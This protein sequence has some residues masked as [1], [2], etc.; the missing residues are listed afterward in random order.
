M[1]D[2]ISASKL[3]NNRFWQ[4]IPTCIDENVLFIQTLETHKVSR[5]R[6]DLA[7]EIFVG[8]RDGDCLIWVEITISRDPL[9]ESGLYQVSVKIPSKYAAT[10]QTF[11]TISEIIGE[12]C[13][14]LKY[15]Q[16]HYWLSSVFIGA[17]MHL[18]GRHIDTLAE[19]CGGLA[20]FWL[21]EG[22]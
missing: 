9:M 13:A 8:G 4:A 17:D 3:E 1:L 10:K 12:S 22:A 5:H 6:I 18:L 2:A 15:V 14:G 20:S 7:G 19:Q 21:S 16:G 11:Y